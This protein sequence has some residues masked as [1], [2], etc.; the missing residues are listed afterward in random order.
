MAH[1]HPLLMQ[2]RQQVTSWPWATGM[3]SC[4][5]ACASSRSC[6]SAACS[7][8]DS[9]LMPRTPSASALILPIACPI[10]P[11]GAAANGAERGRAGVRVPAAAASDRGDQARTAALRAP[12][13]AVHDRSYSSG[14]PPGGLHPIGAD[15]CPERLPWR[16]DNPA[17]GEGR[18]PPIGC[19]PMA[20]A[21]LVGNTCS[22]CQD[23]GDARVSLEGDRHDHGD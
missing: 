16:A 12:V 10:Y 5:P 17:P 20:A 19:G 14:L 21:S 23:G 18:P 4:P 22:C 1:P 3:G 15:H 11:P 9:G 6:T 7:A 13:L 2:D 8:D